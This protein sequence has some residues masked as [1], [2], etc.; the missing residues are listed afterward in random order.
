M[1][2]SGDPRATHRTSRR[3][4][5]LALLA[6]VGALLFFG[7]VAA[8]DQPLLSAWSLVNLVTTGGTMVAAAA[9]GLHAKIEVYEAGLRKVRPLW[10]DD[11]IRFADV[12]RAL[13][14]MTRPGL[15]LF[16]GRG[17]QPQFSV[18]EAAF[19]RFD[20]LV[21]QVLRRLPEGAEVDDPAGRIDDIGD[22]PRS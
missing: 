11:E 12:E 13:L 15:V 19:E 2:L 6:A 22:D 8:G 14:P 3:Q 21:L 5:G 10:W 1:A 16:T 9:Y 7:L 4:R 18:G 17:G 20:L